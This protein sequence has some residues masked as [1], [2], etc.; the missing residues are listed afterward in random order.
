MN[1]YEILG[2][3][4]NASDGE[5]KR[6]YRKLAITYHPDKNKDPAAQ[7]TF[8]AINQAYEVVGDPVQR[9][10]YDMRLENPLADFVAEPVPPRHRDPA[11]RKSP[12]PAP[13]RKPHSDTYYLM[14]DHLRYVYWFCWVGLTL[15]GLF[16]VDSV[17]PYKILED[18]IT[19]VRVVRG[20]R[21]GVAYIMSYTSRGAK[22]KSY[23]AESSP[24]I[25]GASIRWARTR[26]YGS[27]MWAELSD[28]THRQ[29]LGHMYGPLFFLPLILFVTSTCGIIFK[30]NVE[31]CFNMSIVSAIFIGISYIFL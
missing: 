14:R 30:A 11:Y 21:G 2:V 10:A 25:E 7:D 3:S 31:V 1:Y 18:E 16:F 4:R 8:V 20:R 23:P 22:I 6:A 28:G 27:A 5:I 13:Q 15:S 9:K 12:R 19:D 26:I 17:I 24:L 29:E